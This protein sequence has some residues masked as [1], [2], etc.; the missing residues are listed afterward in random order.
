MSPSFHREVLRDDQ[1]RGVVSG[2]TQAH[3][4]TD[5]CSLTRAKYTLAITNH[6]LDVHDDSDITIGYDIGCAFTSTTNRSSLSP[7]IKA[8]GLSFVVNAFHGYAHN[9]LCQTKFH[10]LYRPGCGI[11]DLETMER[12]FSASNNVA[13][14]IR[15]ASQYHWMQALDLHFRQWDEEKYFE[16]SA[17]EFYILYTI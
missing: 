12:V 6:T 5:A 8:R 17:F 2:L 16:L 3:K 11:E 1:K 4:F 9:R 13:R 7:R 14:T 10:I 15:Y